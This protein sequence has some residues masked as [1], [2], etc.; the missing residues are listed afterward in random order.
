MLHFDYRLF[1]KGLIK[2]GKGDWAKIAEEFVCNKTPQQVQS[3]AIIFFKNLQQSVNPPPPT[4]SYGYSSKNPTYFAPYPM[5]RNLNP[6]VDP[7]ASNSMS[8]IVNQS[9]Q[10]FTPV[11][12]NVPFPLVPQ[13][14]EAS[15]STNTNT[16]A[17]RFQTHT[18][19]ATA[20]TSMHAIANDNKEI[21][22]ELRLGRNN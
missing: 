10:L 15:T 12:M 5:S 11:P 16:I 9:Q 8:M 6:M 21:D 18:S 20:G 17:Y 2:Y 1:V 4:Y 13:Y 3:Y 14:G 19:G 22:L 7:S